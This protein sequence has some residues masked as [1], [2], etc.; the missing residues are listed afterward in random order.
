M[1]HLLLALFMATF[2]YA[3]M[4]SFSKYLTETVDNVE[5]ARK[6][7]ITALN[8]MVAKVDISQKDNKNTKEDSIP[9]QI[10]ETHA[11]GEIAIS[12]ADVEI[13]KAKAIAIISK[14]IDSIKEASK[15]TKVS[16][17]E[18]ALKSI[19]QAVSSVEIAKAKA[20]KKI[21][22]ATERVQLSKTQEAK[23]LEHPK[24]TLA[25]AKNLAAMQ[26]AKSVSDVEI[27]KAQSLIDITNSSTEN[28]KKLKDIKE[29]AQ[30][31]ISKYLREL[32]KIKTKVIDE[33]S[34]QMKTMNILKEKNSSK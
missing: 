29:K 3:D 16:I 7:A 9:T 26:I 17:Q 5:K 25:I 30:E 28:T 18:K 11:L 6:D 34:I 14:A 19:I 10:I 12:T 32:K 13:A 20:S 24:E 1:K 22:K 31:N 4:S 27:A 2:T 23:K 21:V 15:E 8:T 33:I